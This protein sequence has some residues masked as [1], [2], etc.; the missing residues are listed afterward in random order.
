[1]GAVIS[2]KSDYWTSK[3]VM[4]ADQEI[5]FRFD[6][7]HWIEQ[8]KSWGRAE[9]LGQAQ[10]IGLIGGGAGMGGSNTFGYGQLFWRQVNFG[11]HS[12]GIWLTVPVL[13]AII[14]GFFVRMSPVLMFGLTWIF[15]FYFS[16][17]VNFARDSGRA[18]LSESTLPMY[19]LIG[20][21]IFAALFAFPGYQLLFYDAGENV[22]SDAKIAIG[23]TGGILVMIVFI[24]F[25]YSKNALVKSK[26]GGL[27]SNGPGIQQVPPVVP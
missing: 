16:H 26:P 25:G 2:A 8:A 7:I 15:L 24:L 20:G 5:D 17:A 11:I 3:F 4:G 19:S 6:Q 9:A 12:M 14:V 10:Q 1:M 13:I 23:A 22:S 18:Q 21:G 27:T